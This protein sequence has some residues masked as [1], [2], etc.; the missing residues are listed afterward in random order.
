MIGEF[1]GAG[2]FVGVLATARDLYTGVVGDMTL[3]LAGLEA[4]IW[5]STYG[6]AYAVR[7][8]QGDPAHA[9]SMEAIEIANTAVAEYRAIVDAVGSLEPSRPPQS[10]W[11]PPWR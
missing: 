9:A 5:A 10:R 8:I 3:H 6:A 7:I 2:R 1:K 4:Q 11:W